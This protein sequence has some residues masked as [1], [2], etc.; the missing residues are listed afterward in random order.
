MVNFLQ[1][2]AAVSHF[3]REISKE[4]VPTTS[5][6]SAWLIF[7]TH[8]LEYTR[9]F[10]SHCQGLHCSMPGLELESPMSLRRHRK[11]LVSKLGLLLLLQ[12]KKRL[13]AFACCA[14]VLL[15]FWIERLL[16]FVP[17][18]NST[19]GSVSDNIKHGICCWGHSCL[20]S[21]QC[22]FSS[23]MMDLPVDKKFTACCSKAASNYNWT[24]ICC[25]KFE[26][27]LPW[28]FYAPNCI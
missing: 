11:E 26:F 7:S 14:I 22:F 12:K 4:P 17:W 15:Y 28:D 18:A 23:N 5:V 8:K 13:L 1:L 25:C 3:Q 16:I 27:G 10:Y 20:V 6:E 21:V 2:A 9:N 24:V 19:G